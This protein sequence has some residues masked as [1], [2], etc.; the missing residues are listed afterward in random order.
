MQSVSGLVS[1]FGIGK[2]PNEGAAGAGGGPNA[3]AAPA[4]NQEP[5]SSPA[6]SKAG[7]VPKEIKVD[8]AAEEVSLSTDGADG[9]DSAALTTPKPAKR[10]PPKLDW[11]RVRQDS[12]KLVGIDATT[13]DT[14]LTSKKVLKATNRLEKGQ[15]RLETIVMASN[16]G[17]FAKSIVEQNEALK[18]ENAA[19]KRGDRAQLGDRSNQPLEDVV[20]GSKKHVANNSKQA[21]ASAVEA[22]RKAANKGGRMN[23]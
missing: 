6:A 17:G 1:R 3:N 21:K 13:R 15:K 2:A 22:R 7:D 18:R 12:E 9:V 14:N 23:S 8:A 11:D 5:P 20:P 19:L 10:V 16:N 4:T